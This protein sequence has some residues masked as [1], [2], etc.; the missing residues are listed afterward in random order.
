[1]KT[2]HILRKIDDPFVK[3][4]IADEAAH[5]PLTLLLMQ[6]GVLATGEFPEDTYVCQEDLAARAAESPY[7]LI[8]YAGITRLITECE[9]I[10]TW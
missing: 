10:I 6:D 2:L 3:S 4:V 7:F 8:N 9:R 1:M 5:R